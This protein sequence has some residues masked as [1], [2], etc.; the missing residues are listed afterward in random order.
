MNL[1]QPISHHQFYQ[2]IP[3]H[4]S[5]NQDNPTETIPN[6][7]IPPSSIHFTSPIIPHHRTSAIEN[8]SNPDFLS[9]K[10]SLK[11][12]VNIFQANKQRFILNGN[13]STNFANKQNVP[14]TVTNVSG[15]QLST[16]VNVSVSGNL[17]DNTKIF[18]KEN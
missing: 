13:Y 1:Q 9:T 5:V 12:N 2:Q 14:N 17:F 18:Y 16:P 11:P 15:V 6:Q 3:L 10:S 7:F 8:T 4:H